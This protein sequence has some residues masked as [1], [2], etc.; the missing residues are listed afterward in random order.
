MFSSQ[1][2]FELSAWSVHDVDPLDTNWFGFTN[3]QESNSFALIYIVGEGEVCPNTLGI[4]WESDIL[5]RIIIS[6]GVCGE[7]VDIVDLPYG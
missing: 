2:E 4:S 7:M 3:L 1:D 6:N 5:P